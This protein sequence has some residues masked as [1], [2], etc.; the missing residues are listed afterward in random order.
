MVPCATL[1]LAQGD[2]PSTPKNDRDT[3]ALTPRQNLRI[4]GKIHSSRQKCQFSH[5]LHSQLFTAATT[6]GETRNQQRPWNSGRREFWSLSR[7]EPP[8]I[9]CSTMSKEQEN[10][11]TSPNPDLLLQEQPELPKP[12]SAAFPETARAPQTQICC[13]SR[14]TQSSPNPDLLFQHILP[15]AA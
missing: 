11:Q 5:T 8:R 13:S 9:L 7:R 3:A 4:W 10:S 1:S 14:N 15:Q 6:R 12:R 2:S